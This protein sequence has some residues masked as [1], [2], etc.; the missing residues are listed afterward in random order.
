MGNCGVTGKVSL[1]QTCDETTL[2]K[3]KPESDYLHQ[4]SKPTRGNQWGQDG[5]LG[6]WEDDRGLISGGGC[7]QLTRREMLSLDGSRFITR[8]SGSENQQKKEAN[9]SSSF[10]PKK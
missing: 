1:G 2:K 5:M 4:H 6:P 10:Y 9:H 8:Q 3:Y 7:S